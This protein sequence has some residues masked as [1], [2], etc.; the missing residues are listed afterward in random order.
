MKHTPETWFIQQTERGLVISSVSGHIAGMLTNKEENA[1]RIVKCVNAC[2]GLE[3]K[4]IKARLD[5]Y[6]FLMDVV[7]KAWDVID[8]E[9]ENGQIVHTDLRRALK[10]LAKRG[11]SK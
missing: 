6:P 8:A 5:D 10:V 2:A 1:H 7:L 11:E 4:E 9:E 3:V